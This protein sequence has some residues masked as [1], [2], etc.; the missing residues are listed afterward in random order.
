MVVVTAQARRGR[1][2]N[3]TE[4]A[5]YVAELKRLAPQRLSLRVLAERLGLSKDQVRNLCAKAGVDTSAPAVTRAPGRPSKPAKPK[6]GKPAPVPHVK[7]PTVPRSTPNRT[8]HARCRWCRTPEV[9]LGTTGRFAEHYRL[10]PS[11]R[12]VAVAVLCEG[13][14]RYP[15]AD[16]EDP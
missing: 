14:G 11:R 2:L 4:T 1:R 3:R 8:A 5:F 6:A 9:P 7:K 16:R 10:G 12:G 13:S 15:I